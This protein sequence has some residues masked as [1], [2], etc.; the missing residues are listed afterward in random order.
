MLQSLK[1]AF[2]STLAPSGLIFLA[3]SFAIVIALNIN[4]VFPKND[5]GFFILVSYSWL[6]GLGFTNHWV[7]PIPSTIFNWHGFLQPIVVS[8][9]SP[10]NTLACVQIGL[11]ILQII[12]LLIW[13]VAIRRVRPNPALRVCLYIV[14]LTTM[15][16]YS[17]RPELLAS[18]QM[19][20]LFLAF[21]EITDPKMYRVRAFISGAIVG[22]ILVTD[23]AASALGGLASAIAICCLRSSHPEEGT[24]LSEFLI[25]TVSALLSATFCLAVIYPHHMLDWL[26]GI[27]EHSRITWSR[28]DSSGF[29]RYYV[30]SRFSPLLLLMFVFLTFTV[31]SAIDASR[32][33]DWRATSMTAC[34]A[35]LGIFILYRTAIRIPATYYNF[36]VIVPTLSLITVALISK[37]Q[38]RTLIRRSLILLLGLFAAAG[39]GALTIVLFEKIYFAP[40][41]SQLRAEIANVVQDALQRGQTVALDPPLIQAID[42]ILVLK[43]VKLLFFGQPGKTDLWP[44]DTDVLIRAQSEFGTLPA[45][46]NHAELVSDQF[47]RSRIN[48][49]VKPE[50]LNYAVYRY[51]P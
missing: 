37:I 51:V 8:L 19:N 49:F 45:T 12:Y 15:L 28:P 1:R 31:A 42:N 35:V 23:P 34:I 22:L 33:V 47:D 2:D 7:T 40:L 36:N 41:Q 30:L 20:L 17:A 11:M 25:L 29:I 39:A 27:G 18:I 10:C 50:S 16:Q 44:A 38:Y 4:S 48:R 43:R 6:N 21:V 32:R 5:D 13:A 46:T 9:L 26:S 3:L 24:I 14:G